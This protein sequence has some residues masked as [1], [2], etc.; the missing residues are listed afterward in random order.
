M[1][2]FR[3]FLFWFA[4]EFFI[5]AMLVANGRA[6]VQANYGATIFTD[7]VIAGNAFWFQKKFVEDKDNRT[8]PAIL[9]CVT[10]GGLGS[11]F[12]IFVTKILYGQ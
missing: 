2:K 12:S 11:C 10:G 9:G 8:W 7:M 5:Y 1:K 6:Y 3:I 4:A